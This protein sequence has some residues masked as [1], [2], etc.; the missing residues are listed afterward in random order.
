MKSEVLTFSSSYL[1]TGHVGIT[2]SYARL[3]IR[4]ILL[5]ERVVKH[6]KKLSEKVVDVY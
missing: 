5:T 4:K 3:A 2:K 6:W 1:V